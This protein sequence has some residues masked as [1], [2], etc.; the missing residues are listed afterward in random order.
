ML[1]PRVSVVASCPRLVLREISTIRKRFALGSALGALLF[2]VL[3]WVAL[4]QAPDPRPKPRAP[5]PAANK[6]AIQVNDNDP[7]VMNLALNNAKNVADYYKSK[8][9]AVT[10]EIVTYGPGLHML[11][12]DTS[13][14]K[15]RVAEMSLSQLTFAAC[16]NTQANMAK[17]EAKDVPLLSEARAFRRRAPDR[18]AAERLCL[19]STL[20]MGYAAV[21]EFHALA[22]V[23]AP[24][25]R[26]N[27]LPTLGEA[28]NDL[29]ILVAL[30]E[31]LHHVAQGAE[32]E[33]LVQGV[34]RTHQIELALHR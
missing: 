17:Q 28:R 11:R 24:L 10:I 26:V 9:Q 29:Q 3:T 18:I 33:G 4:A 30:G 7:K 31:P 20:M 6:V 22:Q 23:E 34:G 25:Q 13:P 8:R 2:I 21:V 27:D 32:G 19:H 15:Q 14:V 1:Q 16:A 12:G 5:A